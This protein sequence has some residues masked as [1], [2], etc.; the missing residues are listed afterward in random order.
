M[1]PPHL[2]TPAPR[3]RP[4]REDAARRRATEVVAALVA[5]S[6]GP[7]LAQLGAELLRLGL[8]PPRGGGRWAPSSVKALLDRARAAGLLAGA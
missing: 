4:R 2:L 8:A 3:R 6:G 7:T 5:G 1:A